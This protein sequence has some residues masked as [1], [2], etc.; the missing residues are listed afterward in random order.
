MPWIFFTLL[1]VNVLYFGWG[2]MQSSTLPRV[3]VPVSETT[4]DDKR[5]VLL[6]ERADLGG[7]PVDA[8]ATEPV[9]VASTAPACYSVGPYTSDD[10]PARFVTRMEAKHLVTRLDH[11]QI[12]GFDYWVFLP[13]QPDES[14]AED[15]LQEL[16][17]HGISGTLV[18]EQPFANAISLGHFSDEGQANSL[19][20][21][22]LAANVQ[23]EL[24]KLPQ[25]IPESWVYVAPGT[26]KVDI[27]KVIDSAIAATPAVHKQ[28]APCET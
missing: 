17:H 6:S 3:K 24:R 4:P 16:H 22:M 19:R 7:R 14:T 27:G 20:D 18:T 2:M 21:K 13:P 26:A 11:D 12:D 25:S 10:Q 15:K 8:A 23:A 9:V 28:P 5:L 1:L